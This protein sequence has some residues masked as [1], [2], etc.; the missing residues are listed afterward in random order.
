MLAGMRPPRGVVGLGLVAALVVA[1]PAAAERPL[2]L[3]FA[4]SL[5][6]LG[7]RPDPPIGRDQNG[8]SPVPFSAGFGVEGR[9]GVQLGPYVGLD[10]L[11]FAET[12]LLAAD[13]RAALALELSPVR[14]FALAVG[15]GVGAMWTA[16]F[17]FQSPSANFAFGLARAEVRLPPDA[18]YG[19]VV[20]GLEGVLGRT[21]HGT[22]PEGTQV[23]GGR[24]FC[25]LLF[26]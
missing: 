16:N 6:A 19:E 11:L 1:T 25:G 3:S 18:R 9:V 8:Y 14:P 22:V 10:A 21:H 13:A 12:A 24:V 4:G 7:A 5:G 17:F 23:I 2:R 26:R 15:A 20:F